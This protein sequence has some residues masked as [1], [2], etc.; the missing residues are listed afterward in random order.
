MEFSSARVD[1]LVR[2]VKS[3]REM[4][5]FFEGRG[6]LLY[7]RHATFSEPDLDPD[8]RPLE[9]VV[10]RF[11]RNRSK[12]ANG[13]VAQRVFLL[14]ERRIELTYHLE[15]HRFIPSKRSFIKPQES[16]ENKKAEDF[17][18]DM[19]SSFQVQVDPSEKPLKTLALYNMLVA[20]MKEEEK[21]VFQIKASKQE[22]TVSPGVKVSLESQFRVNI[23]Q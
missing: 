6:D 11:H 15:D 3:P 9:M 12:P 8:D 16:T 22:V 17:T 10:E 18:S 23:P 13:D 1:H 20:L 2:R 4:T 19:E 21:V 14:A 7:Y 5:E